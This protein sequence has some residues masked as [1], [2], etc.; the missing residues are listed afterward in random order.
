MHFNGRVP[1]A[2]ADQPAKRITARLVGAG[3]WDEVTIMNGLTVNLHLLMLAFYRPSGAR[4]R[5]LVEDHAF[6]SD[7]YAVRSLLRLKGVSEEAMVVARP[8]PGEDTLRTEDLVATI[9]ELGDTLAMV[10][11][12]GV[13]YYTGAAANEVPLSHLHNTGQLMD[14]AAVTAAGHAAGAVVGWDL[15]HAVGNVEL[16]LSSWGA[17]WAVWCSYKYLNSGAGGIAGAF[18]H[19]RHHASLPPHLE[20]WWSNAQVICPHPWLCSQ[21]S[22]AAGDPV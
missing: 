8:R 17:D 21:Q 16:A 19:K 13:H 2:L 1:A 5:I 3:S 14:M 15:A 11:L 9:R 12:G 7:R 4:T 22:L 6:P 18:V 20:G 10:M